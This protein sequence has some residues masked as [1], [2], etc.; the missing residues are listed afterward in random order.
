MYDWHAVASSVALCWDWVGRKAFCKFVYHLSLLS[1][2]KKLNP[3]KPWAFA[4]AMTLGLSEKS[5]HWTIA[6]S[7]YHADM[8]SKTAVSRCPK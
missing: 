3:D 5:G 8:L 2:F 7:K 6:Q 1:G 4:R